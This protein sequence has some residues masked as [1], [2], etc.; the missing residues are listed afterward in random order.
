MPASRPANIPQTAAAR[1]GTAAARRRTY[2]R[3]P[4]M[5]R[6]FTLTDRRRSPVVVARHLARRPVQPHRLAA[7]AAFV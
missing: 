5:A 7:L 1:A 6:C 4:G 3:L 2:A